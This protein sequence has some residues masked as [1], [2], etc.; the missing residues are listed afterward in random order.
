M[1]V[2]YEAFDREA[3]TP[4]ALKVLRRIDPQLRLRFKR[5]FRAVQGLDHPNLIRLGELVESSGKLFYTMELVDGVDFLEYVRA[6]RP[7]TDGTPASPT[8]NLRAV[9]PDAAVDESVTQ[10]PRVSSHDYDETRLRDVLRQLAAALS[11][12]H[13][14][15]MLHRDVKP[16]N[17]LV[18]RS[19]RA[20]L[21]D[22]GLVLPAADSRLTRDG[23][24]VGTAVYMAPEQAVD[25][26]LTAA[27]DWY[28]V[29]VMLY[30][31][32]TGRV[33]FDGT[34]YQVLI[35]KQKREPP[36][37]RAWVPDVPPDLDALCVDL[38]RT[39]PAARPAT[40]ELLQRLAVDT[41]EPSAPGRSRAG[42]WRERASRPS[43]QMPFIG[44]TDQLDRLRAAYDDAAE[45]AVTVIVHGQSG[46]GKSELVR[47]LGR[48]LAADDEDPLFLAGRCYERE[49]LPYK[50]VDGVIDELSGYL[51]GLSRSEARALLPDGAGLVRELFPVLRRIEAVSSLR[52]DARRA[53][54]PLERRASTFAALRELFARIAGQR[55]LVIAIDDL[56][57]SD[58]D[59]LSLLADLVQPP[60]APPVLVVATVRTTTDGE[61]PA[62]IIEGAAALQGDVR[63]VHV[64]PLAEQTARQLVSV[65]APGMAAVPAVVDA[66][67]ND[68][69]GHPMFLVELLRYVEDHPDERPDVR[70][71]DALWSRI[72]LLPAGARAALELVCVAGSPIA[73]S[74]IT[75]AAKL[76]GARWSK[77]SSVLRASQ[78][79]RTGG[80]S[81]SDAV[82]PYHDRIR[83]AVVARL[84][85]DA[86]YRAH[87]RLVVA[88][89][90][91]GEAEAHPEALVRHLVAIGEHD[92]A[93]HN[94]E[95]AADVAT[96]ALAFD[97]AADLYATTLELGSATYSGDQV[98]AVRRALADALAN[99]G[100]AAEAG[101]AFLAAAVGAGAAAKL[102]CRRRAAEQFLISGH[103]ERGLEALGS[104]LHH[105]DVSM[106]STVKR[107]LASLLWN[108]FKL[109]VRGRR[110]KPRTEEQ[111]APEELVRFDVY[112]AVARGLGTVDPIR[113]MDFQSRA[114]LLALRLGEPTR[115]ATAT[116]FEA[117]F[118]SAEGGAGMVRARRLLD[119]AMSIAADQNS[120]DLDVWLEMAEG[121]LGMFDGRFADTLVHLDR[122]EQV[123]RDE[124]GN[125]WELNNIRV[126]RLQ[127]LR[128]AG[129]FT[130]LRREFARVSRIAERR[131]DR[132]V[133]TSISRSLSFLSLLDDDPTAARRVLDNTT[134]V[135]PE[136]GFHI[137][138]W[139]EL[140]AR[141]EI[142]LYEDTVVDHIAELEVEYG[143]LERS[144]LTRIQFTRAL[145][146]WV[147]ARFR[148]A[149][150]A[151]T[152][153]ASHVREA[154]GML[155]TLRRESVGYID[156]WA[157]LLDASITARTRGAEAATD[158]LH[159][160]LDGA[161]RCG[162]ALMAALARRRMG[163][164][165][166]EGGDELVAATD[167]WAA[168]EGIVNIDR[169]AD[170]M[171]PV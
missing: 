83:E 161:E 20:V 30:E 6:S 100:R 138:H 134:W 81:H 123:L 162:M 157:D 61:L 29:G 45:R 118:Y 71:D 11:T 88:L 68:A 77:C 65:L 158:L 128:F 62:E 69:N 22:F 169:L 85:D 15:D 92:R 93:A 89:D 97:R 130:H 151:R 55:R 126:F 42:A 31:A 146:L 74:I 5:E 142:V 4:V 164:I 98:L 103:I 136:G 8:R 91:A 116:A 113:G 14:A 21:L 155:R 10:Q 23:G 73:Q 102:T 33:P 168:A 3:E 27:A 99:A 143:A 159:S 28:S 86:R 109:R 119:E 127:I 13:A 101:D 140:R 95:R 82:E 24:A 59:S 1:G 165:A 152:G 154:R 46:M 48:Q 52:V 153:D 90:R 32:L 25:R 147:R 9:T 18:D 47:Q 84:S 56:Q 141:S 96:R 160:A 166:T 150:H 26:E 163:Q 12:L 137:Q 131:G 117:I 51:A 106:P 110:W 67:V 115:V 112:N 63:R 36:P 145:A 156:V 37:P 111:I 70:L 108:R 121:M 129:R 107:A 72:E 133:Q 79:V 50:G 139:Y 144:M 76:D 132:Y 2:V 40:A 87:E 60:D 122:A 35:D 104:V 135:P 78:L 75:M 148:L 34:T 49:S 57:W 149:V 167:A 44:R 38:L 170:S 53:I 43:L 105:F 7:P 39:D 16:S 80:A 94:A 41:K 114:M 54:D 124:V 64:G 120:P 17:V 58:R 19:G 125:T 171:V 66:I